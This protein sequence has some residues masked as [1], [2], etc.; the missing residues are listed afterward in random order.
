MSRTR[1]ITAAEHAAE[2]QAAAE[3]AAALVCPKCRASGRAVRLA[4]DR[5]ARDSFRIIGTIGSR[6]LASNERRAD[7]EVCG[8]IAV[9]LACDRCGTRWRI[10]E[11]A[12]T[13]QDRPVLQLYA[14]HGAGGVVILPDGSTEP[15]TLDDD[16]EA[17]DPWDDWPDDS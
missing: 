8:T 15:A 12:R 14:L 13:E 1:R 10:P 17:F 16:G 6:L 7:R 9:T 11:A 2:R 5:V 3:L 4:I